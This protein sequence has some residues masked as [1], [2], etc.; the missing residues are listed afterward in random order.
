MRLASFLLSDSLTNMLLWTIPPSPASCR[1]RGTF[2]DGTS[3]NWFC[4]LCPLGNCPSSESRILK[5]KANN[6]SGIASAL[7]NLIALGK[8]C[9]VL[10]KTAQSMTLSLT[11]SVSDIFI[12]ASSKHCRAATDT[13]DLSECGSEG[14]GDNETIEFPLSKM[15]NRNLKFEAGNGN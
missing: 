6:N 14:W 15:A 13:C 7:P 8:G 1:W 4:S 10:S 3:Y 11:H 2:W 9:T 12:S 5:S